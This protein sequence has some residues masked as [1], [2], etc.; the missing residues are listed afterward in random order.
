ML[1]FTERIPRLFFMKSSGASSTFEL[2]LLPLSSARD[3]HHLSHANDDIGRQYL[4]ENGIFRTLN[5]HG[6]TELFISVPKAEF[7]EQQG[8]YYNLEYSKEQYRGLDF[9]EDLYTH[10]KFSVKLKKGDTLGIII[11]TENPEHRNA[12]KLFSSEK[13]RREKIIKDFTWNDNLKNLVLAADQFIVKRNELSTIMAGYHW[14]AD[15]GRDTMIALP[16]LCL[17][18]G[19]F[20]EAKQILQQFSGYVNEGML[21][22]RFPDSW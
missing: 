18:T 22:N 1:P 9:Q 21:P 17:V 4:F 6:G 20:K 8:W 19:R 3:F 10:G 7:I 14:F 12:F 5:Y 11:S 16:G 15:W 2:Q 13:K